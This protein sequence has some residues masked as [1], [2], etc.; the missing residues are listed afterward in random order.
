LPKISI[1]YLTRMSR[2]ET[3]DRVRLG[4]ADGEFSYQF[5]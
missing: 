5:E 2:G 4:A 3:L 1:E